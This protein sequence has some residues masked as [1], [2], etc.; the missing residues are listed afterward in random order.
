MKPIK[1]IS[2][3]IALILLLPLM[4]LMA[5]NSDIDFDGISENAIK[6]IV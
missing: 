4:P 3:I 6:F 5:Q 2:S 1:K